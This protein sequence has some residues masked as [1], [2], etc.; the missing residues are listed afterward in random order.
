[1]TY[2]VSGIGCGRS[3]EMGWRFTIGN[4]FCLFHWS[5]WDVEYLY[6]CIIMSLCAF[7]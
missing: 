5:I 6:H 7:P 2:D 1:M 3:M 4:D